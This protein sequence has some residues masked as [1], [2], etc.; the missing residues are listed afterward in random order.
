MMEKKNSW[1]DVFGKSFF[2]LGYDP[3]KVA[4]SWKM[5]DNVGTYPYHNFSYVVGREGD[6]T[7]YYLKISVPGFNA[8]QITVSFDA[9]ALI[10][11]GTKP[12]PNENEQFGVKSIEDGDFSKEF[13][14][15]N[16]IEL[17]DTTLG[18]GIL[19]ITFKDKPI[20]APSTTKV[21]IRSVK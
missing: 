15:S 3:K 18:N 7:T 14:V 21:V 11:E 1:E 6:P 4:P 13:R 8:D 10:I 17:I 12:E 9:P 16:T 2:N 19:T 20:G 5:G